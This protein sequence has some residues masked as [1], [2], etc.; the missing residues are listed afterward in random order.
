[1]KIHP[2]AARLRCA[3]AAVL[4]ALS[5][6]AVPT[7]VHAQDAAVVKRASELR[8]SPGDSGRVLA[9]LAAD[10]TVTRT[11]ER[12][13][14]WVRA[15]T[16][17]G[18]TGWIHLFDLGPA[19]NAGSGGNVFTGA[20]RGVQGLFTKQNNQRATTPTSTIGIRGLGAEDL[21]NAQPDDAEVKKMQALHSSDGDARQFAREA[22]LS[23]VRVDPLPV[24]ARPQARNPQEN[25]Q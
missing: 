6:V 14:P 21:A 17:D 16:A 1:M 20:L 4:T 7:L 3:G 25:A 2:A 23:P 13:G 24:P 22:S 12:Q 15:R 11:G 8:E 18:T 10:S 5:L 19:S 9:P